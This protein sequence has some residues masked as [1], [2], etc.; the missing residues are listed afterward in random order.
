MSFFSHDE[1]LILLKYHA[2]LMLVSFLTNTPVKNT[3]A[4]HIPPPSFRFHTIITFGVPFRKIRLKIF[5]PFSVNLNKV[6]IGKVYLNSET[7]YQ[8]SE[9]P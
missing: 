3:K 8:K 9:C 7:Y 6:T 5:V 1:Q 4:M 2:S